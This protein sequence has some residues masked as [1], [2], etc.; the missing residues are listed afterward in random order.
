MKNEGLM[1]KNIRIVT[2]N[3]E[4]NVGSHGTYK[5]WDD[6]PSM[7]PSIPMTGHLCCAFRFGV[8]RPA[9]VKAVAVEAVVVRLGCVV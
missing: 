2:H 1:P 8:L 5:S 7:Y 4:R 6:P 3:N 9:A